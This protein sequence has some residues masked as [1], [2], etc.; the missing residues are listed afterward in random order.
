MAIEVI[1]VLRDNTK[2]TLNV[3][4]WGN[5][6]ILKSCISYIFCTFLYKEQKIFYGTNQYN[7]LQCS[8]CYS[9]IVIVKKQEVQNVMSWFMKITVTR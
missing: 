5:R 3:Q 8:S 9:S 6:D 1:P 7:I 2:H 4:H